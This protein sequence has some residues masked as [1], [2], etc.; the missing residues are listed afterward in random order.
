[1]K[2]RFLDGF[3]NLVKFILISAIIGLYIFLFIEIIT[4]ILIFINFIVY[5]YIPTA[6]TKRNFEKKKKLK[7]EVF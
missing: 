5:N 1:M 2:R 6:I 7:S 3:S 4:V